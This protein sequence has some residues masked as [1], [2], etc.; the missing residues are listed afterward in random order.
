VNAAVRRTLGNEAI[1]SK[2]LQSGA[3][4]ASSSAADLAKLLANDSAKWSRVVKAKNMK[5]D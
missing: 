1:K 4:P 5:P 2:L 3:E